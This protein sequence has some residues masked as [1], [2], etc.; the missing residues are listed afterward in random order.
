MARWSRAFVQASTPR[1]TRF[2]SQ[3][4]TFFLGGDGFIFFTLKH[5]FRKVL[6]TVCFLFIYFS[7]KVMYNVNRTSS[8]GRKAPAHFLLG[9]PNRQRQTVYTDN[10]NHDTQPRRGGRFSRVLDF[11][12]YPQC[13]GITRGLSHICKHG[14]H[15]KFTT[16]MLL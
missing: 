3:H 4:S 15:I 7:M 2:D 9:Y 11:S 12:S 6:H 10:F 5:G 8:A 14:S 13:R 1:V 16:K